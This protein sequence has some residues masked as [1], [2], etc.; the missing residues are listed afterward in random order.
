MRRYNPKEIESKWQD[1]WAETGLY[2]TADDPGDNKYYCLVMFPYPSGNLHVGHWYNFAPGDAIAR[3]NRMN[4]KELLN[5]IGFDAFGLPAENAAIKNKVPPAE[6]TKQNVSRMLEQLKQIGAMY[7][8]DKLVNTSEPN[9]YTWT[10]WIFLK[11]YEHGLAYRKKATVNWC[12][13]DQTVLAN[14]Q[15]VGDENRCERCETVVIQKELD[16]W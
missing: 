12:P 6:W 14:E 10:Q 5:P 1:V 15:V 8:M 2:K 13:K 11:L 16:Q 3:F 4:G 7:D 9:Y